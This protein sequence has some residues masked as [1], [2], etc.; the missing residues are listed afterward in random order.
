MRVQSAL[1]GLVLAAAVMAAPLAQAASFTFAGGSG[2]ALPGNFDPFPSVA[3]LGVGS[4]VQADATLGLTGPGR[5]T[6]TFL[7][8]E[9]GYDNQFDFAGSPIFTN[10]F[11]AHD[12]VERIAGAGPVDFAFSTI[13]PS[14]LVAN[15]ASGTSPYGS[16]ALFKLSDTSV[17]ALFNDGAR[18][19]ADYDDMAVRMDVAPVPLPAAAWLILAGLGGLALVKR[20]ATA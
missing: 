5:V 20:R 13:S 8:S 18:V 12:P 17:Y 15:G 4:I 14:R 11:G 9:A 7:G 19:D 1:A 6:F 10:H 3:G 2:Y 16:I